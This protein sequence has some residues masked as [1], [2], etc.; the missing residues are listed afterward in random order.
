MMNIKNKIM[1]DFMFYFS[2]M[3]LVSLIGYIF[4]FLMGRLLIP[5]DYGA[6]MTLIGLYA[7]LT[8]I[9]SLGF[10]EALARFGPRVSDN[11]LKNLLSYSLKKS[12]TFA[13]IVA[14]LFL[15]L[16]DTIANYVYGNPNLV[17]PLR[18]L[19]VMLVTG[20]FFII[21]RGYLQGKK[22]F[23]KMLLCDI[24]AQPLRLIIPFFLATII[25]GVLGWAACFVVFALL[26][27]IVA[28]G[29]GFKKEPLSKDFLR[30]GLSSSLSL[31]G[32]WF[33]VQ[34]PVIFLSLVSLELSGYFA[35]AV[36]FA[37]MVLFF[38]L[39]IYGLIIPHLSGLYNEN[40]IKKAKKLVGLSVLQTLCACLVLGILIY[41]F[42]DKIIPI[43]YTP[44]YLVSVPYVILF[45]MLAI[46]FGI[47]WVLLSAMYAKGNPLK[48]AKY[49]WLAHLI[50]VAL[51]IALFGYYE[52][53][54]ILI[55]Y[56]ISQVFLLGL[57]LRFIYGNKR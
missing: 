26:V 23:K 19:G 6:M 31:A 1:S 36:V 37:Q 43:L 15:G 7:V 51:T 55:A 17:F 14:L 9:L 44:E 8:P 45:S 24:V 16:S 13:L 21:S 48:R 41:L 35:V 52:V 57:N 42:S 29:K 22:D 53:Y 12:F 10:N 11:Q 20:I 32:Y 40:K 30:F 28:F 33:Y 27:L 56:F 25:G 39:T 46:I 38:P 49:I 5:E 4:Y 50:S 18:V 34:F 54:A 3:A 47:N 2:D